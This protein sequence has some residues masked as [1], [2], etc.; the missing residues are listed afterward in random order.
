MSAKVSSRARSH[1]DRAGDP[2]DGLVNLF[3]LG[4]VL[5]VAFLLAALS[6]INLT[7]DALKNKSASQQTAPQGS[8]IQKQD[9]T[10][11]QIT[12]EP[13]SKVVGEGKKLGEVYQLSD[14]RTVIVKPKGATSA[15]GN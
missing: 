13:G 15:T 5:A 9:Q 1:E 2:L 6:S 10:T 8:V 12:V 4:I 14:G 11:E 7:P 3:D